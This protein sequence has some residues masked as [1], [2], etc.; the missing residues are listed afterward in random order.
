M[1]TTLNDLNI[2]TD[3]SGADG[4][5]DPADALTVPFDGNG[6]S[7]NVSAPDAGAYES[8]IYPDDGT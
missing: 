3:V 5:A 8:I 2:E 7:R 4:I 1:N 6:T